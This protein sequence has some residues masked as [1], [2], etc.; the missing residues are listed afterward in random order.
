MNR[1]NSQSVLLPVSASPTRWFSSTVAGAVLTGT[2]GPDAINAQGWNSTL[3]GGLGDDIYTVA[4][5]SILVL[6]EADAGIDT[7]V[8]YSLRVVLPANI[9]NLTALAANAS[10]IGNAAD[11]VLIGGNGAQTLSGGGG[12]DVL[13]GGAGADV[14][15]LRLGDGSD[16]ITDFT[17]RTDRIRLEG[18]DL[19]SFAAVK[20]AMVQSGADTVIALDATERVILR[21]VQASSLGAADFMLPAD[22]TRS[23]MRLTFREEF[24]GFTA[25]PTGANA[26]WKSAYG[27]SVTYRTLGSNK[28][29]Q[30]YSDSSVGVNPF[31]VNDGVLT[32]TAAPGDNPLNLPYNSGTITTA[33]SFAQQYGYFEARAQL[34]SGQGFWPAFWLMPVNGS[35]PPEIDIFEVLGHDTSTLYA[36]LHSNTS[37]DVSTAV[38][39]FTDLSA[40][41]NTYGLSWQADKIRWY[42]NGTL[43]AEQATPA[44]MRQPMYVILNLG[45]GDAGSWPGKYAPDM[46]TGQMLIDYV[47]VW[48]TGTGATL[49]SWVEGSADVAAFGGT[50]TL[51]ADGT[52]DIYDFSRSN[53]ALRMDASGLDTG[54]MHTVN[55]SKLGDVVING[56]ATLN[57]GLGA[58]NDTFVFGSGPSRV[59]GNAGDDV[60][61]FTAGNLGRGA[62]ILDFRADLGDGSEHDSLRFEGFSPEARLEFVSASGNTQYWRVVDGDWAS[63]SITLLV[64]NTTALLSPADYAFA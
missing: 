19:Q 52:G 41:F 20:A 49:D 3:R 10:A 37:P 50:Y 7:L 58:G 27:I 25:S 45:V 60:F 26:A 43:I 12:N 15:V 29:A 51:R 32:I 28:E 14:F 47:R 54:M 57:G 46:P 30:Y 53:I 5:N 34:P 55:G 42:L 2:D 38:G 22:P 11:N 40:G 8:S 59:Y 1:L 62:V 18:Y 48:Q 39:T 6:E 23:G 21:N 33:K 36:S 13:A 64:T 63:P 61:V 44:D 4:S 9:E 24:D 17:P 16:V 56:A 31:S 35:W